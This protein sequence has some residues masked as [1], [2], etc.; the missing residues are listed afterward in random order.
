MARRWS[1]AR[2][3]TLWFALTTAGLVAAISITSAVYLERSVTREIDSLL[4]EELDEMRA[5]LVG[6]PLSHAAFQGRVQQL[7][8]QHP[9]VDMAWRIYGAEGPLEFGEL[10]LFE[11]RD[12]PTASAEIHVPEPGLH[13]LIQDVE[14]AG[15]EGPASKN[16]GRSVRIGLLIDGRAYRSVLRRYGLIALVLIVGGAG[17]AVL[18]GGLF[19]ARTARTLRLVAE[20][21][22]TAR[23]TGDTVDLAGAPE[24]IRAVAEA[25][26]ETLATIRAEEERARLLIAG[27]AHELR[28]PLQNLLGET[29]V[30]LM[31]PRDA[32]EYKRTLESHAE[33]LRDVARVVDNLVTLCA[34]RENAPEVAERFDLGEEIG[35]RLD[36]EHAIAE[37][38]GVALVLDTAGDLRVSG[39]REALV[40]VVRNLV[41]N[42]LKWAP[43]GTEVR[44]DLAGEPDRVTVTVEDAGGG[45]PHEE[46]DKIFE[47]FYRGPSKIGQRIGY[48]LGLAL[49]RSAVNAHGG[50][51]TVG[52]SKLGGAS[53]RVVLPR[54]TEA[55]RREARAS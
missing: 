49:S 53:F 1:L 5:M 45:V 30:L 15:W 55:P 16:P 23:G 17:L 21:A 22:R 43:R 54:R 44:L 10:G 37:R 29:E 4:T 32:E 33:E 42:A 50:S 18:G 40:L 14:I 28:S 31:R 52:D 38:D 51:I 13:W 19:G 48:G 20:R 3:L 6:R 47:P 9:E 36:R 27:L 26:D 2:R 7:A 8:D 46:R 25:F 41:G 12:L 35:L 24:E 11:G 34:T 39:D